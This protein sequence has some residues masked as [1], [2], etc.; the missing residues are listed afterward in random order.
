M[1]LNNVYKKAQEK[2]FRPNFESHFDKSL[3]KKEFRK[4]IKAPLILDRE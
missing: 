3:T 4:K 1:R 2:V